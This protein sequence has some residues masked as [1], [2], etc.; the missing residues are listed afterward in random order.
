MNKTTFTL[1]F[2]ISII[3][4]STFNVPQDYSTIQSAIDA[5]NDGDIITVDAN[6]YYE[7]INFNGKNISLIGDNRETTIIDGS[8]LNS[9]VR[10]ENGENETTLISN[11][12]I[13]N[14]RKGA[15]HDGGFHWPENYGGGIFCKS[16]SPTISNCI[17]SNNSA[18]DGGGAGIFIHSSSSPVL[19]DVI[20]TNNIGVHGGGIHVNTNSHPTL[21][22]CIIDNNSTTEHYDSLG[23]ECKG[24]G[25]AVDTN[26]TITI[27]NST[28]SNNSSDAG[29]GIHLGRYGG[30]VNLF[31]TNSEISGNTANSIGGGIYIGNSY[32][33]I[34]N[35]IIDNNSVIANGE[36][37]DF[38]GGGIYCLYSS[39]DIINS[40]ITNNS[41]T[42][43]GGGIMAHFSNPNLENVL[44]SNNESI[45]YSSGGGI[46][47]SD[48]HLILNNSVIENNSTTHYGGG[49]TLSDSG[50]SLNNVTIQNNSSDVE[51]G[52][53]YIDSPD[54]SVNISNG[55]IIN[56]SAD[57]KQGGGIFVR[58]ATLTVNESNI[59]NN[60]SLEY[61]GGIKTI[62]SNLIIN[63][64][65]IKNNSTSQYSGGGLHIWDSTI[66]LNRNLFFNNSC[67]D[68]GGAIYI[69]EE[70]SLQMDHCTVVNNYSN[71]Y[72]AATGFG[73]GLNVYNNSS[74]NISN[75]IIDDITTEYNFSSVVNYSNTIPGFDGNGNISTDFQFENYDDENY[76]LQSGSPCINTGD[77]NYPLDE[78]GSITEMGAHY[79]PTDN[80]IYSLEFDGLNDY[81]ELSDITLD[82]DF[83]F[84]AK[85]NL[86]NNANVN[87]SD[88]GAH[89]F[90]IGADNN[91]TDWASFAFGI[92]SNYT[93]HPDPTLVCEMSNTNQF[94]ANQSFPIGEVVDILVT[95]DGG[96]LIVFQN[97]I[98]V[99]DVET[100]MQTPNNNFDNVFIGTRGTAWDNGPTYYYFTG[101]IYEISFWDSVISL[102]DI[103]S[104]IS[105]P[106]STLSGYWKFNEGEGNTLY[107]HSGN[108]NHGVIFESEWLENIFGD[109]NQ[110]GNINVSDIILLIDYI[111]GIDE[112]DLTELETGDLNNSGN[113]SVTD[114]II[115][116]EL[117]F[118]S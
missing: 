16:S 102:D 75:S 37:G 84:T 98:N 97:N 87:Y 45:S 19:N 62:N 35:V 99:M 101:K 118:S 68:K 78:D 113:I 82:S 42:Y 95:F 46:C 29:G 54:M 103:N 12:T 25:I 53:I 4:S 71:T 58:N 114:I 50:A 111:I 20:I 89:I 74:F 52:G 36:S 63:N 34:D 38:G 17:V 8:Q 44:V 94:L 55:I 9:V 40:E 23:T 96:R 72:S 76:S 105:I 110:D 86:D 31:I 18:V 79:F 3:L 100:G 15:Q 83:S 85:V 70:S 27:S 66:E 109:V 48:S 64:S 91:A 47:C 115:L 24:G 22:S 51:G 32:A 1:I 57:N 116:I 112:F 106:N 30:E 41:S 2:S 39:P 26:C 6:I 11:F 92:S 49:L 43:D 108:G 21:E 104:G 65:E 56:N 5:S 117:I 67:G 88:A 93:D 10:F 80:G 61:G 77:P 107:D 69:G 33:L 60:S 14:G 81:V 59:S 28:I 7:N 73:D 13:Q 90:S